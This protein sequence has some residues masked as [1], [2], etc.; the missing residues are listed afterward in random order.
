MAT[1][2]SVMSTANFESLG[3]AWNAVRILAACVEHVAP[4]G[5]NFPPGTVFE[6]TG[7]NKRWSRNTLSD[8]AA[9]RETYELKTPVLHW[10]W[11]ETGLMWRMAA[12]TFDSGDTHVQLQAYAGTDLIKTE[13]AMRSVVARAA[14]RGVKVRMGAVKH[15]SDESQATT[16]NSPVINT[17][18][19][20]KWKV[21]RSWA[22]PHLASY[23]VATF[24]SVTSGVLLVVLGF[25]N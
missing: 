23:V 1:T 5:T 2:F 10:D 6:L 8:I 14:E 20:K 16:G 21:F 13:A 18:P 7:D 11:V 24:A 25:G 17:G 19:M 12:Q 3:A 4:N 9:V 15:S 22:G